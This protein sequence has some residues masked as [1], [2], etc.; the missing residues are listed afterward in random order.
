MK[1][2]IHTPIFRCPKCG[3]EVKII[4]KHEDGQVSTVFT[5]KECAHVLNS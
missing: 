3:G 4:K 1:R 5:C 2:T